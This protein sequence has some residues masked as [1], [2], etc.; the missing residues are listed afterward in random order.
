MSDIER[1]RYKILCVDDNKNNLFTLKALL[2]TVANIDSVE[3]LSAKEALSVLLKQHIDL[4]LCD[5]QMPD[6]NGF[7]LA[8]MIKSNKKTKYIPIIFVTAVFKSEEFIQQGFEIGAVDY[9]TKPIDDNQL[10]NKITLYLKVFDEKNKVVQSEKRFYNIAQSLG[11]GIY[12]IDIERKTTFINTEALKLLGFKHHELIG[13]NIHEYIHYKD[14]NN[15][16][17]PSGKCV[18]H[19]SMISAQK[20]ISS[21]EYLIKKD[22]TFLP[23]SIVSTPLEVNHEVVGTV[24]V[25]HDKTQERSIKKLEDEKLKNQEQMIHSMIDMIESRDSYTAGH[26]RRV[27]EYCVLIAKEM[28]YSA[29]MIDLIRN[30]AWLHDIGK[31]STPD[32]I[33]LKP[34]QLDNTEYTLIK[35]HLNSGYEMLNKID[36]YKDIASI[37]REHHEKFDGSGYPRGLKGNE[38]KPLSRIM[39]VADA[40]DAM[41][42][43]RV[44][45]PRKSV[46]IALNELRELSNKHFHPE[47]VEA[48]L[49]ALSGITISGNIS[50]LP[51][52]SME[53]QR[54]SYFY[55]DR[56]TKL[57]IVDYLS[58][59]LRYHINTQSAYVYSINL[60]NFSQYN[61]KFSWTKGDKFLVEFAYFLDNLYPHTIV[62]RVEGD[63]FIILSET[64]IEDIYETVQ[65]C[66][67]LKNSIVGCSVEEK[68]YEDINDLI[69]S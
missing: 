9:V 42:T 18:V 30:A 34:G 55:K 52:T 24:T 32:S 26:T 10:L 68:F 48:A 65:E 38:I 63:D 12:T 40:F 35:D 7:E 69:S 27:S 61:I 64:R 22:G 29:Q 46:S 60:N 5:V 44:Y 8:R 45:K 54:F 25:F 14:I 33:L 59:I 51:Q 6:I 47:V 1:S 28:G 13:K 2:S 4:I 43:N 39:I 15:K 37:M 49:I 50:Q 20:Y 21:D 41:T 23:V 57:F 16:P 66:S 17:I 56:L 19:N 11:D 53:E 3:V 67:L 62:F 36:Q 31:I 58:L